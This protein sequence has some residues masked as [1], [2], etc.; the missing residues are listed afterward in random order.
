[1]FLNFHPIIQDFIS[2]PC[3]KSLLD[4]QWYGELSDSR[5][6]AWH[7]LLALL[8]IFFPVMVFFKLHYRHQNGIQPAFYRKL[9]I[10]FCAPI[11]KFWL[12]LVCLLFCT[13]T[14]CPTNWVWRTGGIHMLKYMDTGMCRSI[15]SLYL[16]TNPQHGSGA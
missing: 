4:K 9:G 11:T 16:Q 2:H 8:T 3:C 12:H 13:N 15:G 10:F 5:N 7:V 14:M 6:R 1:M